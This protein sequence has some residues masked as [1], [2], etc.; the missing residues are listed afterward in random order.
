M[1]DF[2]SASLVAWALAI[3]KLSRQIKTNTMRMV[4]G[5]LP[6][7]NRNPIT[8]LKSLSWEPKGVK[9]KNPYL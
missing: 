5:F 3:S 2:T 7:G 4:F 9:G 8:G 1:V 6:K